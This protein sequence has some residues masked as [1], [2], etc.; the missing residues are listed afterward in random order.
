[1]L[2]TAAAADP[3]LAD[4]MTVLARQLPVP[5]QLPPATTV[6][7][8]R[9]SQLQALKRVAA[10][11]PRCR[12]VAVLHGPAGVGKTALAVRAAQALPWAADGDLYVDLRG[13]AVGG[14]LP[15]SVALARLLRSLGVPDERVPPDAD[16][17]VALWRSLTA[18]RKLTVV[19]DD[20]G[21]AE[22]VEPLLPAA[23]TCVVLVT[24]RAPLADLVAAG[25]YPVLVGPLDQD[26]SAMLLAAIC[27]QR[28]LTAEPA[29]V[30][31][32]VKACAGMPLPLAI[33]AAHLAS[34]PDQAVAA[35]AGQLNNAPATPPTLADAARLDCGGLALMSAIDAAYSG[36]PAPAQRLFQAMLSH[37]GP[38]FTART[39]GAGLAVA[40]DATAA[41]LAIL[42]HARLLQQPAPGRYGY[43]ALVREFGRDL[44][45]D[46]AGRDQTLRRIVLGYLADVRAADRILTPYQRYT[47]DFAHHVAGLPPYEFDSGRAALAWLE[48]ERVNLVDVV[49]AAAPH[50]PELAFAVSYGM[51]PLF[52]LRRHHHTR[53]RVDV[54]AVSCAQ[55][56]DNPGYLAAALNRQAWGCYDRGDHTAAADLFTQAQQTATDQHE[57]AAALAGRGTTALALHR[58]ADAIA[59]LTQAL[60]LYRQLGNPRRIALTLIGLA[61]AHTTNQAARVAIDLL[62]QAVDLLTDLD[63]PD[64]VNLARARTHLGRALITNGAY[65]VA[66]AE[67]GA[68]LAMT[69]KAGLT[70]GQ[71]QAHH[72]LGELALARHRPAGAL[73]HLQRAQALFAELGDTEAAD[74]RTMLAALPAGTTDRAQPE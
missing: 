51:W 44:P 39:A 20:A 10:R 48:A 6:W 30:A 38:D 3:E 5:R 12:A 37:P 8:N 9:D 23:A 53:Q 13:R 2:R 52:H 65:E 33:T 28:R 72:G 61:Q 46:P 60:A 62:S 49:A 7:V 15:P 4:A 59:D 64:P 45:T 58:V 69:Q 26:A 17:R 43:P 24:S 74:V 47:A 21:S 25:A 70:R 29:A 11:A 67:L 14:S 34:H 66:A 57:Q 32:L 1:M 16:E 19:L 36:L 27:G 56:L 18:S 41:P 63:A 55:R 22:Q 68:A 42:V 31:D 35:A 73:A 40:Q 71:A 50:L 54:L